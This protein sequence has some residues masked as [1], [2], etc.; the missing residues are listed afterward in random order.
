[1]SHLDIC[2]VGKMSHSTQEWTGQCALA[3][4]IL[5]QAISQGFYQLGWWVFFFREIFRGRFKY[6]QRSN[7]QCPMTAK[8]VAK[9]S[10]FWTSNGELQYFRSNPIAT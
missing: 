1:M 4:R 3:C 7:T 2:E 9:Q 5:F 10:L 8:H 6:H